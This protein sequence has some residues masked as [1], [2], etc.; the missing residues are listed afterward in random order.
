MPDELRAQIEPLHAIVRAM[1]LPLLM[2]RRRGRR[3]D[4][5]MAIQAAAAGI[6]GDLDQRQGPRSAGR[7]RIT[8]VNT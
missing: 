7:R 4:R 1:G 8:L 3:R 5:H 6:L 2:S